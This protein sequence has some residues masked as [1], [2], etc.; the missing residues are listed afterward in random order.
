MI[1]LW[2]TFISPANSA[3]V[4]ALGL[5]VALFGF[6]ITI[7]QLIRT[8]KAAEAARHAADGATL[9]LNSFSA[10]RECEMARAHLK[11]VNDAI[12]RE[13]WDAALISY[14]EVSTSLN[15]LLQCNIAFDKDVS[16]YLSEGMVII[17]NNCGVIEKALRADAKKLTKGKQFAA[18][19][20]LDP[21]VSKARFNLERLSS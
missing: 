9:R 18:L 2:G 20:S 13:D 19:R 10:L 4:G 7:W 16:D 6:P 8:K 21:I 5:L 11:A 17:G 1:G 12:A 3:V 14:Q 15:D